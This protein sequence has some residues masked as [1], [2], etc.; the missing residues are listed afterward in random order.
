MRHWITINWLRWRKRQWASPNLVASRL[1]QWRSS[2]R[3]TA[4]RMRPKGHIRNSVN[5]KI[6]A[7]FRVTVK[8]MKNT[9]GIRVE[10]GLSSWWN[11]L[12]YPF[13][14]GFGY[15]GTKLHRILVGRSRVPWKKC[16]DAR[17]STE[18]TGRC[19]LSWKT[20]DV[21]QECCTS[22]PQLRAYMIQKRK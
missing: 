6:M 19:E 5:L 22:N 11:L 8:Q 4:S 10:K 12:I 2:L 15:F 21:F 7:L 14:T 17:S 13:Y 3:R 9:N 1:R 18:V 20:Y 16:L